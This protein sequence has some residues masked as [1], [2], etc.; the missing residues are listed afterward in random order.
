MV[1]PVLAG[2]HG[3]DGNELDLAVRLD[4]LEANPVITVVVGELARNRTRRETNGEGARR[5]RS[6]PE[7]SAH[8]RGRPI[9]VKHVEASVF[10]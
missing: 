3:P 4:A 10:R 9:Q 8:L 2:R 1:I 6:S 5:E 7:A